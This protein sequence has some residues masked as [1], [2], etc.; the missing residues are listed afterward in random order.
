[1]YIFFK[2]QLVDS[3]F[4]AL[5]AVFNRTIFKFLLTKGF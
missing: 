2:A 5:E 4:Q 1:M 3:W